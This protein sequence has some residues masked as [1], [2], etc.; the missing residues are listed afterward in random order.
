MTGGPAGRKRANGTAAGLGWTC[1]TPTR[2][3]TG[4]GARSRAVGLLGRSVSVRGSSA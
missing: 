1:G 3:C 4:R 2:A